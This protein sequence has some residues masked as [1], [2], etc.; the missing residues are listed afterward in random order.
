MLLSYFVAP[1]RKL[2]ITLI[3]SA[4]RCCQR[5]Y[6]CPPCVMLPNQTKKKKQSNSNNNNKYVLSFCSFPASLHSGER[7]RNDGRAFVGKTR[8]TKISARYFRSNRGKRCLHLAASQY[9]M[10]VLDDGNAS[11]AYP[12][13]TVQLLFD[14]TRDGCVW[15]HRTASKAMKR[16]RSA[17]PSS[18]C[19]VVKC[20][21][22]LV[23]SCWLT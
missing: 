19:S 3:N 11:H 20:V 12:L 4:T 22:R 16:Q 18:I 17:Q 15:A 1:M 10:L 2:I 6:H 14:R 5:H 13:C 23:I 9:C 21:E 7:I 8:V